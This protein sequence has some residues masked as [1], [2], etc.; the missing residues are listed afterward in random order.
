MKRILNFSE[1]FQKYSLI[2]ESILEF[3]KVF[4][5]LLISIKSD[6]IAAKILKLWREKK[7]LDFMYNFID[8]S[9][10]K[11][12]VLF[13]TDKKI[14]ELLGEVKK[15]EDI[16]YVYKHKSPN[17]KY[18]PE[19]EENMEIF[20]ALEFDGKKN[21]EYPSDGTLGKIKSEYKNPV[22]G[23]IWT[24][25]VTNNPPHK[26]Y[27]LNLSSLSE[28][29]NDEKNKI[30]GAKNRNSIKIGRIVRSLLESSGE[31]VVDKDVENFV[32]AFKSAYDIMNNQ[33]AKIE[34]IKGDKI[35]FWYQSKNYASMS[36]SI[37][38]SCMSRVPEDFF[39]IYCKNSA[40]SLLIMYDDNGKIVDGKYVSDKI[41]ARVTV[42]KTD[43]GDIFMDNVYCNKESD[44]RLIRE[45]AITQG[46]FISD[47]GG[48]HNHPV[49]V[50]DGKTVK[51][52]Q[53][54]TVTLE[55]ADFPKYPHP[56]VFEYMNFKD[57][58]LCCVGGPIHADRKLGHTDGGYD[59]V[60]Y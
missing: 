9:N 28:A 13:T 46:W 15:P 6:P 24:L 21:K 38:S 12:I 14:K 57:K 7:D 23:K 4:S 33:F 44:Q 60:K 30:W 22:S 1:H 53:V 19:N 26:E 49:N 47:N 40:V 27:V 32:N 50:T 39:G 56:D 51:K 17:L 59:E 52:N 35:A 2:N 58:I 16:I 34:L 29:P 54:Y 45:Y 55:E 3:S 37:S 20:K 41:V 8:I 36:G 11:D 25:F 18:N 10:A 42:W 43:Q 48:F 31:K 5:D